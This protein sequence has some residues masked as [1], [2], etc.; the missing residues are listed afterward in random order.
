MTR[1]LFLALLILCA[2]SAAPMPPTASLPPLVTNTPRVT[3]EP[4][5]YPTLAPFP[6]PVY[7]SAVP[8]CFSGCNAAFYQQASVQVQSVTNSYHLPQLTETMVRLSKYTAGWTI[9]N[10]VCAG[11]TCVLVLTREM[12]AETMQGGVQ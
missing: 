4:T 9:E 6:P 11:D 3:L 8:A 7:R 2:C 5:P 10:E 1:Y 12:K